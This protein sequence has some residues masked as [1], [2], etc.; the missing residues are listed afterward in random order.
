MTQQQALHILKLGYNVYL[1]G[2]AG[3]G[4]THVLNEYIRYLRTHDVA[5][6][7]TASTGIAATHMGGMTIHAW[8]GLG[9]RGEVSENDLEDLIS[10]PY[11]RKRLERAA[12][13]IIDEISM[14]HDFRLDLINHV[15]QYVKKNDA[16]FGGMQVVLCGDFFQLPPVSRSGEPEPRFVYHA[17]AWRDGKFK[18]CY[19]SEQFRQNDE[20]TEILNAIRENMMTDDLTKKLHSRLVGSPHAT[21]TKKNS[22]A[23]STTT[24]ISSKNASSEHMTHLFTHNI[25]VDDI[26]ARRLNDLDTDSR[27]YDMETHGNPFLIETLKKSCLAPARLQLKKGARVMFVKN[28]FEQGYVNGTLG[29]VVSLRGE[30]GG[31]VVKIMSTGKHLEVDRAS[32]T[33]DEEGK[34]LA[35]LKQYPLRLA[36]AITVHKSQ[37]MSLDAVTVDLSKSFEPG[38]GYVALSR[39]RTLAG[40]TITNINDMAL[41]VHDEVLEYDETLRQSSQ[42]IVA[43]FLTDH[44]EAELEE[45]EKKWIE[46]ITRATQAGKKQATHEISYDLVKDG[47]SL[48]EAATERGL[49]QDTVLDHIEKVVEANPDA[50]DEIHH[51]KKNLSPRHIEAIREALLDHYRQHNDWRLAPVKNVLDKNK[52]EL[53]LRPQPT[54]RD[55]QLVRL[56]VR[57]EGDFDE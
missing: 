15:L 32:W 50:L 22:S 20:A 56:F 8:S 26:N 14:L 2:P 31:P 42:D 44:S 40:L 53:R 41:K 30:F 7:I 19:L 34:V 37:G 10:R 48:A 43:G 33:I 9:V 11:L 5:V 6:G 25:D 24:H 28:N 38:M 3:S 51:I 18:I 55:I 49:T 39:V 29:E 4:K 1:T 35:E 21:P 54:Y 46:S 23:K 52:K 47:M 16:P 36:W 17:A 13:L 45:R 12:V 27:S 57:A